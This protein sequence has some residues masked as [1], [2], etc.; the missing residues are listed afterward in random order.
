MIMATLIGKPFNP[1]RQ[2]A[3]PGPS[4][5]GSVG[6]SQRLTSSPN[7][8]GVR[9]AGTSIRPQSPTM[10]NGTTTIISK[11]PLSPEAQKAPKTHHSRS[12]SLSGITEGIGNLNR[13]SQSTV[14]SKASGNTHKRRNSFARRLSGSFGSLAAFN[15]QQ[16]S[17]SKNYLKKPSPP[18]GN[19][20]Q[21]LPPNPPVVPAP[22]RFSPGVTLSSLSYA[23]ET[24][25]T[26]SSELNF[27]PVT[28]DLLGLGSGG[29]YFGDKWANTS[30]PR[31]EGGDDGRQRF[32][33]STG[34]PFGNSQNEDGRTFLSH[35]E[36]RS[37][38]QRRDSRN[39]DHRKRDPSYRLNHS[40]NRDDDLKGSGGTEAGSSTSSMHSQGEKRRR[41]KEPSQK[42]MLAKA[43]EKANHAV[44]LDHAQNFEGAVT[45]YVD[46]CNL[47]QQ[48][49]KRNSGDEDRRKLEAIVSCMELAE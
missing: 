28:A 25:E 1:H 13:W 12:N 44:L 20:P 43:L 36:A 6:S 46:A 48:V 22:T 38:L 33:M 2:P 23:V 29:D 16:L 24:A 14:S 30:P 31:Q 49:M 8:T 21:R 35:A 3:K 34:P 4:T 39:S 41:R 18:P 15:T 17:P 19:S 45:A 26:P 42:I 9:P 40:R 37:P 27:T 47:L 5:N 32:S 7:R 10:V 11:R